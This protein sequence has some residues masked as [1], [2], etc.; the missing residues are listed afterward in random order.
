MLQDSVAAWSTFKSDGADVKS[1]QLLRFL[2]PSEH[3]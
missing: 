2:D 3:L 1:I